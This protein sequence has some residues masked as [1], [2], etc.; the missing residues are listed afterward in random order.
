MPISFFVVIGIGL[1]LAAVGLV[2]M[3]LLKGRE[4]QNAPVTA[5]VT[6]LLI[7]AA[8]ILL[9]LATSNFDWKAPAP[10]A[11][12]GPEAGMPDI[13][14]AVAQ[15]E[16]RLRSEPDDLQGWLMLGRS[17][18]QLQR[19]TDAERA[20]RT[21]LDLGGG[22]EAKLGLAE[23]A[24]L[25]DQTNLGRDA[26]RMIEEVLAAEPDNHKALF[27]GGMVAGMRDDM[28]TLQERWQHLLDLSPPPQIRQFLEAQL[29]GLGARP[30][31][32]AADVAGNREG[33]SV[34]IT[35]SEDL[36]SQIKPGATLF[37]VAREPE[38]PGPPVA[39]VRRLAA[40]LPMTVEISDADAM[41]PGRTLS[42]LTEVQLIARIANGGEPTAQPGDISGQMRLMTG[43]DSGKVK[44]H[45]DRLL[46]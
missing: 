8:V 10:T 33:I 29:A 11:A 35:V 9:Y 5:T 20:Y 37:L 34:H 28:T 16:D 41:L 30:M 24:V 6:A 39:V 4:G 19:F 31:P 3:P 25:G 17:Y 32:P 1:T 13:G 7:P 42:G 44:I 40:D 23:A 45:M 26:G 38:R 36:A 14:A 2:V 18:V 22:N 21:A 46:P 15:L 43:G 27:Y 12:R